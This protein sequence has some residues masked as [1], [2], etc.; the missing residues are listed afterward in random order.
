MSPGTVQ[1][2]VGWC[3]TS[4]GSSVCLHSWRPDRGSHHWSTCVTEVSCFL[5][6]NRLASS[7]FIFS[8]S[9]LPKRRSVLGSSTLDEGLTKEINSHCCERFLFV[10]PEGGVSVF[11]I[12]LGKSVTN[13][14]IHFQYKWPIWFQKL[15][16]YQQ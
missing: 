12:N 16:K 14:G 15:M 7:S 1:W 5:R 2:L 11:V 13:V 9:R 3:L 8:C 4:S 6:S 10:R